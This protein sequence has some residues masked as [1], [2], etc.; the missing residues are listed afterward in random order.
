MKITVEDDDGKT[1]VHQYVT[2]CYLCIRYDDLRI[3]EGTGRM[4][5]YPVVRSWS[6]GSNVRELVK[7]VAQSLVELQDFLR[8]KRNGDSS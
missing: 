7:E 2:D 5:R 6:W 1:T 4:Y 8:G 3:E